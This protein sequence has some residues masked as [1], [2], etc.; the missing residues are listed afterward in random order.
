MSANPRICCES[1]ANRRESCR[2]RSRICR[3][4]ART[5]AKTLHTNAN[6]CELIRELSRICRESARI[7]RILV[8]M[9]A[10]SFENFVNVSRICVTSCVVLRQTPH[11]PYAPV[12][13]RLRPRTFVSVA[14]SVSGS[15]H[16]GG[17]DTPFFISSRTVPHFASGHATRHAPRANECTTYPST[18]TH[19]IHRGGIKIRIT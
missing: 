14:V 19:L 3:E 5:Y 13:I 8:Q 2:G 17:W 4:S 18:M 7:N 10:N 9:C 16:C 12:R 11:I 15:R 6:M 1:V